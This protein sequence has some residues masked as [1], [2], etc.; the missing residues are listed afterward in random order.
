MVLIGGDVEVLVATAAEL[1]LEA[2][3]GVV[4]EETMG[5]ML[6]DDEEG[7]AGEDDTELGGAPEISHLP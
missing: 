3:T 5:S 7:D 4:L 2:T 6:V 1:V